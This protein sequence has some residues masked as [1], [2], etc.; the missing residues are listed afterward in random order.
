[1]LSRWTARIAE[2]SL[3]TIRTGYAARA[4]FTAALVLGVGMRGASSAPRCSGGGEALRSNTR[5][6]LP[7]REVSAGDFADLIVA[8]FAGSPPY[9]A[10]GPARELAVRD[11]DRRDG[12]VGGLDPDTTD[13]LL[14]DSRV[15]KA[16]AIRRPQ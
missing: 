6:R 3:K 13:A 4:A 2:S 8:E 15:H 7:P 12:A 14:V 11:Q 10:R 16:H 1:M 9:L 5:S